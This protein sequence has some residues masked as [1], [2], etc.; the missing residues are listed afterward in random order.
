MCQL[1]HKQTQYPASVDI[2]LENHKMLDP[3]AAVSSLVQRKFSANKTDNFD[4]AKSS[5]VT[6]LY[7]NPQV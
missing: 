4:K 3:T 7:K 5:G 1:Y 6:N 2:H